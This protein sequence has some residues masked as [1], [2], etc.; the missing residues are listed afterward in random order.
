VDLALEGSKGDVL[1]VVSFWQGLPDAQF[2][3]ELQY[4]VPTDKGP[5]SSL[6]SSTKSEP[7]IPYSEIIRVEGKK[8][9]IQKNP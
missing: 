5:P 8:S 3:V 1:C 6:P 2:G 4:Q 7:R 9:E